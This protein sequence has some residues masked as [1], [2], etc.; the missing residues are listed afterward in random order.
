MGIISKLNY[1]FSK[2]QK[3]QS[4]LLAFGLF[5]GA[6]LELVGVSLITKLVSV[7]ADPSSIHESVILSAVYNGLA[8]KSDREFFL[9]LTVGLILVYVLKNA[10]LLWLN[11]VQYT[12]I[13]RNQ[14]IISGRL[15][16]CYLKKPYTY[17]L[18]K[19][20]AE[21]VRNVMLD[22]ERLFQMLLTVFSLFSEML[23]C[24]LLSIYLLVTDWFITLFL[25]I[26]LGA[27]T[28]LYMLLFKN[29]AKEYGRV[30][31]VYDGKMHQSI[32]QA[33][34]AVKDIKILH[35]EKYFVNAFMNYGKRKM[36]A[37]RNNNVL[38]NVP[39]YIIEAVCVGSILTVLLIKLYGGSDI[40]SMI[41][42]LAAFVVAA[43]KLLP[44]AS[45]INN[46]ANLIIFLKPSVDLIYRDIKDTED[47]KDFE[48]GDATQDDDTG[49]VTAIE[50]KE[51][52]YRYPHS[53]K[54]VLKDVSI[55]IPLGLA[56]GI[57][58]PSGAGK[59]TLADVILGIL[60]PVSGAV[61]YGGM[62]VHDNPLK[63]SKKLAYIPQSIFLSDESVRNNVAFGIEDDQID[64]E[65]VWAALKEAQ[66]YDFVKGLED[67]LDTMVGE[68]GVRLS[69]GQRQ[70]I[71]IARALYDD[72]E[73]LVL[74]EATSALD[75]DTESA[76]MEA[77]DSL[78]GRKTL[79]IIAHR[80][81]TIENCQVIFKVEDGRVIKTAKE[82]IFS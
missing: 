55:E 70:R 82:E 78:M 54:Y 32:N 64:D 68:R 37:V 7:V 6:L 8:L 46:Y 24:V 67:G 74:D 77:I 42:Q 13:Y 11:Y 9:V 79:I 80:L 50:L 60:R 38:G 4:L 28:G 71:G 12:F 41:P 34:G 66:L 19:N 72:P 21:M 39:K 30:N 3:I 45:K 52:S 36:T 16:D 2:K 1:I 10:F 47:M 61:M 56:V 27:F 15:I 25:V 17:H 48:I 53:E 51:V 49:K 14:L 63:W 43:F 57:V 62:N 29:K 33:L 81:T 23:I 5:L 22:S 75:N 35:R 73:I 76:V 31:Q 20:S 58:G 69:G 40:T 44:A 59:S 26:V 65:R 18:D